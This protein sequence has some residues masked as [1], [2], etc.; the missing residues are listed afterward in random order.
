MSFPVRKKTV[1]LDGA[2]FVISPLTHRAATDFS[3]DEKD[4]SAKKD[5]RFKTIAF[6]LNRASGSEEVTVESLRADSDP[7][8]TDFLF[9]E[10]LILSGLKVTAAGE[11]KAPA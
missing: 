10:I 2:E 1:S 9:T 3:T 6:S 4:E 8:T 5:V 11:D 7:K